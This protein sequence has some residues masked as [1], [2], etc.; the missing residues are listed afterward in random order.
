[1]GSGGAL[2]LATSLAAKFRTWLAERDPPGTQ[3]ERD[4]WCK[5]VGGM[6][7]ALVTWFCI[8]GRVVQAGRFRRSP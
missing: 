7:S 3:Q 2:R 4:K 1:M 8:E 5:E 6:A